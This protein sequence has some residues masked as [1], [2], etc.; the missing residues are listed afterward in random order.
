MNKS[1]CPNIYCF[2]NKEGNCHYFI[3]PVYREKCVY[4]S[5]YIK[6][7]T[8]TCHEC[9]GETDNRIYICSNCKE[10]IWGESN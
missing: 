3:T 9:N 7:H 5:G 2:Y 10:D 4:R 8:G 6:D 1:D